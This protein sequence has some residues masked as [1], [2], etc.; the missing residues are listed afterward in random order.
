MEFILGCLLAFTIGCVVSWV[1]FFLCGLLSA[2]C[3]DIKQVFDYVVE[4][5]KE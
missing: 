5:V 3:Q 2:S 1:V 4:K